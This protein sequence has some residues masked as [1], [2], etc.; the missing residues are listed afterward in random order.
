MSDILKQVTLMTLWTV[1][2]MVIA[3]LWAIGQVIVWL[4]KKMVADGVNF[5]VGL[6]IILLCL[7]LVV[8]WMK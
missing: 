4:A 5:L 7:T 6:Y 8:D 1:W 2:L 3:I